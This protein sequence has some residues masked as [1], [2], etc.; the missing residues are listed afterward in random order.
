MA[1]SDPRGKGGMIPALAAIGT[2]EDG[3][4]KREDKSAYIIS[5]SEENAITVMMAAI[6]ARY[7]PYAT[8]LTYSIPC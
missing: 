2:R 6:I 3:R 7:T 8:T 1:L 5:N 4:W